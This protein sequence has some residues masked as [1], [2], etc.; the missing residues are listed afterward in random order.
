MSLLLMAMVWMLLDLM[1][2]HDKLCEGGI[3]GLSSEF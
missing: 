2:E 3:L 1:A